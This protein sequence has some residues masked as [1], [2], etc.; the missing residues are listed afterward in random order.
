MIK[1]DD[2]FYCGMFKYF[3]V[4][5][6]CKVVLMTLLYEA[7]ECAEVRTAARSL[8]HCAGRC[9]VMSIEQGVCS[10]RVRR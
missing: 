5:N 7:A 9:L 8:C 4:D 1:I 2:L 3:E 10:V 6:V